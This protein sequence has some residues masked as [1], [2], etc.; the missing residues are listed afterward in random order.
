MKGKTINRGSFDS[1]EYSSFSNG[2]W[3]SLRF[4]GGDMRRIRRPFVKGLQHSLVAFLQ[5]ASATYRLG[6][7]QGL[8][9]ICLRTGCQNGLQGDWVVQALEQEISRD[10]SSTS[11][12][13]TNVQRITTFRGTY[14]GSGNVTSTGSV[15][16][17]CEQILCVGDF[18]ATSITITNGAVLWFMSARL[19]SRLT[20]VRHVKLVDMD[21]HIT[22]QSS[23]CQR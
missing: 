11:R 8:V 12:L 13:D 1:P 4:A 7:L 15:C 9:G 18:S 5:L 20:P 14:Y 3:N 23:A 2:V 19:R 17:W 22:V 10:V 21:N 6:D 16:E